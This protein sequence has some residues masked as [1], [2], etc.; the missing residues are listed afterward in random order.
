ME[1]KREEPKAGLNRYKFDANRAQVE[2]R[3]K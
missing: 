1:P 3:V 2:K